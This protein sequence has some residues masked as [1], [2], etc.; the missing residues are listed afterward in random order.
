MRLKGLAL[1]G[2]LDDFYE[3]FLGKVVD[4]RG[5]ERDAVHKV[6]QGRVWTGEQALGLGLVDE[7]GGLDVALA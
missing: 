1:Q 6:A 7:L 3:V 4:G 2:F 5:M